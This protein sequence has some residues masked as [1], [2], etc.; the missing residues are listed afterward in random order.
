[1]SQNKMKI[2]PDD[3]TG[4]V[5]NWSIDKTIAVLSS[6]LESDSAWN[7]FTH[8]LAIIQEEARKFDYKVIQADFNFSF[9]L[10]FEIANDF[11]HKKVAGIIYHPIS[12]EFEYSRNKEI[13][14]IFERQGIPVVLIDK[15]FQTE[16]DNYSFVTIDN[17][18]GGYL[19][20]QHLIELG[21]SSIAFLRYP[22]SSTVMLRERGYRKALME[23]GIRCIEDWIQVVFPEHKISDI[24]DYLFK[25]LE[26][27]PTA[28]FASSDLI[29]RD[30]YL[31]LA[32][33]GLKIPD[34]VAIVGFDDL[35]SARH[36]NP[37]LTTVH[38]PFEK[39]AWHAVK[40]LIERMKNAHRLPHIVLPCELVVR[41]SCGTESSKGES[42]ELKSKASTPVI[43]SDSHPE[44]ERK[45]QIG[46]VVR[47]ISDVLYSDIFYSKIIKGIE[48]LAAENKYEIISSVGFK[49]QKTEYAIIR[50]FSK[51]NVRGI[52]FVATFDLQP[53]AQAELVYL[54]KRKIPFVSASYVDNKGVSFAGA[55][56]Y[57]GGFLAAQRLIEFE[58]RKIGVLLATSGYHSGAKRYQGIRDAVDPLK[59]SNQDI[60]IF[61]IDLTRSRNDFQSAYLWGKT[62]DLKKNP[63]N[64]MI[65]QN[66]FAA[67]GLIKAF[68]ERKIRVPE[69]IAVIGYDNSGIDDRDKIPLTTINIPNYEIGRKAMEIL[70]EHLQG[71]TETI[72]QLLKPTLVIRKS[73]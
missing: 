68:T 66:D 46:L 42:V 24:C 17:Q 32:K 7:M 27:Q 43:L 9:E 29:V 59:L 16:P 64:G 13:I 58:R 50:G 22:L 49:D 52:I 1:M 20:T 5:S 62:M 39:E 57:H 36:M 6:A 21:H 31:Q 4:S 41:E 40:F 61:N 55:D 14:E 45:E 65:C 19:A 69:D 15:F 12:S 11:V 47:E 56:E 44:G 35:P 51:M 8:L 54:F 26:S 71:H 30:V 38:Q 18:Q 37:P 3:N 73:G 23:S 48:E 25:Q 60:H 70:L 28:I 53:P 67:R 10:A 2:P 34:D 63:I 33:L 72:Q